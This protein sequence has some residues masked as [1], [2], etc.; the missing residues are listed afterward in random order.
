M[1]KHGHYSIEPELGISSRSTPG[2]RQFL[3]VI[4]VN[5]IQLDH[6]IVDR[7]IDCNS[8]GN[9]YEKYCS[10]SANLFGSKRSVLDGGPK[11]TDTEYKIFFSTSRVRGD[12]DSRVEDEMLNCWAYQMVRT[13]GVYL[14]RAS[15]LGESWRRERARI[16]VTCAL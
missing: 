2:V 12:V 5:E 13:G 10:E 1:P 11:G 16:L 14:W 6:R 3:Q 7:F 8:T 4:L 9:S 15:L